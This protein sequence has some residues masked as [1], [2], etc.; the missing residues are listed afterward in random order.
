MTES[1][2]MQRLA[3]L[4]KLVIYGDKCGAEALTELVNSLNLPKPTHFTEKDTDIL[5][6][7]VN[8]ERLSNNP[9]RLGKETIKDLYSDINT[10]T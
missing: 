6:D 4:D 3:E 8:P 2:C 1:L 9:V 5:A 7:A 10:Y